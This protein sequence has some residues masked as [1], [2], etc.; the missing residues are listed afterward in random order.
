MSGNEIEIIVEVDDKASAKL[1][2]IADVADS[3]AERINGKLIDSFNRMGES[4]N[5]VLD[6]TKENFRSLGDNLQTN[7]GKAAQDFGKSMREVSREAKIGL[8]DVGVAAASRLAG[9]FNDAGA[10]AAGL[11][12][13]LAG[14]AMSMTGTVA[15]GTAATGGLNLLATAVIAAAAAVPVLMGAFLALAPVLSSVGGLAGAAM[16]GLFGAGVA[17][18][19]LGIG[20]GGVSDAWNAYGKS[21]GGGGGASKAAGE[22][23]YQA[24]RRIEQAE[25]SLARAKRTAREASEDVSRARED[26]RERIEDLTLALISQKYAQED[27]ADSVTRAKE[28]LAREQAYGN[29]NSQAEAQKELERA[30]H[31]YN[32]ETEQLKDLEAEKKKA[33]KSGIEGSE[34]VQDALDREAEAARAVTEAQKSLADAKRKTE[35]ASGG[36]A[37]GVNAFNEAMNKLSPNAQKFVR[38]LIELKERFDGIRRAV[39]DRLFEGLDKSLMGLADKWG[40]HAERILGNMADSLNRVAKALMEGLGDSEFI[41]NIEIMSDAFG[42]FMEHLGDAAVDVLDAF[43]RI[44][45]HASPIL[46][47]IGWYIA[48]I[49]ERFDKWIEAAEKSGDLDSFMERAAY[50]LG[51]IKD[52]GGLALGILIDFIKILF[53]SSD[54]VGGGVLEG[55]KKTLGDIK[56][57]LGDPKN[58]QQIRDMIDKFGEFFKKLVTKWIPDLVRFADQFSDLVRPISKVLGKLGD[59]HHFLTVKLPNAIKTMA[60]GGSNV[61]DGVRNGFRNAV[62][63][64]IGKWNNLSFSLPSVTIFGNQIGGGTIGTDNI[65]YLASGGIS[66]SGRAVINERGPEAVRLPQ[67]SMVYSAGDSRRMMG[68]QGGG[69]LDLRIKVDRSTERGLVDV[70]LGMLRFEIATQYGGDVQLALGENR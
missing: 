3:V 30:E 57:W 49:A 60:K 11:G 22:Q 14:T 21:A 70:L 12:T 68:G 15:A 56:E 51:L 17:A 24:A 18:G 42:G 13:Q 23:A 29:G 1:E 43:A 20:L 67:G 28:K 48:D 39:Q 59:V 37:G 16:A 32:V 61:F 9:S 63:W 36:A 52:I 2:R 5:A 7:L 62:N 38:T 50:Y 33:D 34:R 40:P 65:N 53:P 26:E 6:R 35:I 10:A 64:I 44:G 19:T 54:E 66:G 69:P 45:A 55:I 25:A 31:R 27:A 4:A 8:G 46:E 47:K 58:Q 41:K